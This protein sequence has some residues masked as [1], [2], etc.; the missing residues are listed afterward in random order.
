[1]SSSAR[2]PHRQLAVWE[3]VRLLCKRMD[4]VEGE[5]DSSLFYAKQCVCH[6]RSTQHEPCEYENKE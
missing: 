5:A 4:A 2:S 3:T 6:P 1:M